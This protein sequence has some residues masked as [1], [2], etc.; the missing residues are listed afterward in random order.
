MVGKGEGE[1]EWIGINRIAVDS[2]GLW[3]GSGEERK[4]GVE[5]V[6]SGW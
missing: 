5:K 4:N 6:R 2:L 1:V 3:R